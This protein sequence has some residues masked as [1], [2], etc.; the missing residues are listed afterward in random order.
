MSAW[1]GWRIECNIVHEVLS[2]GV[3]TC[4]CHYKKITYYRSGMETRQGTGPEG[5]CMWEG[6]IHRYAIYVFFYTLVNVQKRPSSLWSLESHRE[7]MM[8]DVCPLLVTWLWIY[9][10]QVRLKSWKTAPGWFLE[11]LFRRAHGLFQGQVL[12]VAPKHPESSVQ[13]IQCLWALLRRHRGTG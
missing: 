3:G 12:Q 10:L 6:H 4:H 5:G 1:E 7:Q 9:C 11:L 13:G 8:K 2:T